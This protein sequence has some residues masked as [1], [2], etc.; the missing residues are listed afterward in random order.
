[1]AKRK[2]RKRE[3]TIPI[4]T[5]AGLAAGMAEPAGALMAG[6]IQHALAVISYNYTGYN[7]EDKTWDPMRMQRG[8]LPLVI[9]ALVSKFVGGKPLNINRRLAAAG[10]P[11]LRI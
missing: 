2:R 8:L 11:F 1:M 5:V 3:M 9:G 4:A 7:P 10:I 6:D